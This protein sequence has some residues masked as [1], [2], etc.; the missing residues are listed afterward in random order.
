MTTYTTPQNPR[1]K[2]ANLD[3]SATTPEITLASIGDLLTEKLRP[4]HDSID[5]I[6]KQLDSFEVKVNKVLNIETR[7]DSLEENHIVLETELSELKK[8]V[9]DLKEINLQNDVKARQTNLKF[10]N[11]KK[12]PGQTC[13]DT[14]CNL[15]NHVGIGLKTSDISARRIGSPL[16][17]KSQPILVTFKDN[18][19]KRSVLFKGKLLKDNKQV[20]VSEDFP[21]EIHQRRKPLLLIFHEAKKKS[22]KYKPKLNG[23]TLFISGKR[24]KVEDINELP[25]ELQ[26]TNICTKS[27]NAMIGFYRFGSPFSNHNM[28]KFKLNGINYTSVEQCYFHQKSLHFG[29]HQ[30]AEM[31]LKMSDPVRIK[32]LGTKV[33]KYDQGNWHSVRKNYMKSA[34][35]AKF[36]QSEEHKDFLISTGTDTIFEASLN[37]FWGI[38]CSMDNQNIWDKAKW[39]GN[40]ML[41]KILEEVRMEII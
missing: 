17:E 32:K 11:C 4:I 10:V 34:V 35:K 20:I 28:V 21:P 26:P 36:Q 8:E 41:G 7:V 24:Y 13:E 31:V 38:G 6:Q 2:R 3:M 22:E 18:K 30:T 23:D 25:D 19:T 5:C 39:E 33:D 14:I 16:A 15:L 12:I 29:D 9:N 27:N 37:T 1:V 40:N